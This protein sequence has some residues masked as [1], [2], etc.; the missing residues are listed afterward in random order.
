VKCGGN[1]HVET[2]QGWKRCSCLGP[3]L[4]RVYIR[5]QIRGGRDRY[6]EVFDTFAPYPLED[7]TVGGTW[8]DLQTFKDMVWR[9]LVPLREA[10]IRYDYMDAFRL[11]DIHFERDETY[12]YV[13]QVANMHLLILVL[14]LA[15]L[16]NSYFRPL[17]LQT[18]T[19]RRD[20]ARP[21]WVF[22][23]FTTSARLAEAYGRDVADLL[24]PLRPV[25]VTREGQP[26]QIETPKPSSP[27]AVRFTGRTRVRNE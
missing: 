21:T 6:P 22:A 18:L 11:V 20:A 12:G 25:L 13:R 15:D 5:P 16:P 19:L 2:P 27:F 1:R 14:G 3:V 26:A 24:D 10:G 17:L 8:S 7:L 4:D 9:S 23:P